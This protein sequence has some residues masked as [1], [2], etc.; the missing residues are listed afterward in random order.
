MTKCIYQLEKQDSLEFY[1]PGSPNIRSAGKHVA[2]LRHT[3][4]IPSQ[5]FVLTLY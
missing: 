2:P 1:I 4:L 3:I 5:V